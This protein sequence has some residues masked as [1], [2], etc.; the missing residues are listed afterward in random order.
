ML[1]GAFSPCKHQGKQGVIS[2]GNCGV[3]ARSHHLCLVFRDAFSFF[4]TLGYEWRSAEHKFH[5]ASPTLV[6]GLLGSGFKVELRTE[7][8]SSLWVM[9]VFSQDGFHTG[10]AVTAHRKPK[11]AG[12]LETTP[13]PSSLY[14]GGHRGSERGQD[15]QR[16]HREGA[17]EMEPGFR[18]PH[19]QLRASQARSPGG[20]A[21]T[22]E[23]LGRWW[24]FLLRVPG[25]CL[26]SGPLFLPVQHIS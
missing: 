26:A 10:L 15:L 1:E 6:G 11:L 5:R 20:A 7:P 25:E 8:C 14:R 16:P 23:V 19:L 17:A 12:P 4:S 24:C 13:F 9:P 22:G 18:V 2:R 3:S 21:C